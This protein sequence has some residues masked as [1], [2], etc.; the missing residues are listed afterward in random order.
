MISWV[1]RVITV[2][3]DYDIKTEL[4]ALPV[5]GLSKEDACEAAMDIAW[6]GTP[7]CKG[8]VVSEPQKVEINIP[9]DLHEWDKGTMV[10]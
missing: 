5:G 10:L 3:C 6:G 9:E 4:L 2:D 1:M 8:A 7:N